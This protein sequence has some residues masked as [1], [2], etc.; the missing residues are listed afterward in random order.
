MKAINALL[1]ASFIIMAKT[2]V[3]GFNT[4]NCVD[5][6]PGKDPAFSLDFCRTTYYDTEKYSKCCFVKLEHSDKRLFHCYPINAEQWADIEKAESVLEA[7]YTLKSIDCGSSY[8]YISLL[9]L[10]SLLF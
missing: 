5:Y 9:L 4:K 3:E 10:L 6:M 8:L 2:Q 1:L 7:N